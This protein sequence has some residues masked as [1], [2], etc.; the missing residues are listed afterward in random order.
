MKRIYIS[1][2][3]DFINISLNQMLASSPIGGQVFDDYADEGASGLVKQ[4]RGEIRGYSVF[5][6]QDWSDRW[7]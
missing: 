5:S 6:A 1:P 4:D 3:I 2:E 7:E